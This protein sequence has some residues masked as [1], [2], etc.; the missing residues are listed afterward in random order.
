[1]LILSPSPLLLLQVMEDS[2]VL[3][4]QEVQ[5]RHE[6]NA[7]VLEMIKKTAGQQR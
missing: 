4:Q 3:P 7:A 5:K 6:A 2:G 1:M